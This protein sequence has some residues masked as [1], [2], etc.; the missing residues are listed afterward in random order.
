MEQTVNLID[1]D[2]LYN[3][4]KDLPDF[5][6]Y[7]IP[8]RWYKKYN[9]KPLAPLNA[10]QFLESNHTFTCMFAPKDLTPIVI[11]EPQR[12]LSGNVIQIKMVQPEPVQVETYVRPYDPKKR[13]ALEDSSASTNP[14]QSDHSDSSQ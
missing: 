13:L 5:L 8:E 14:P 9:I 7:P 11:D 6:N 10:K 4:M 12:D 2:E 3:Q 1:E